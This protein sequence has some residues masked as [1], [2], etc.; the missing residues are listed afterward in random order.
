MS[1]TQNSR[2]RRPYLWVPT[3]YMAEGIPY[4][5]VMTLAGIMYNRMGI[6]NSEMALFTSL[7]GLPWVIKPL[8]SPIV[9][10]LGTKRR[11]I[12]A[13]QI[14]IACGFASVGLVMPGE[15]YFRL[16]MASFM[17]VAF[18]SATHDIAADGFY[19]LA[20]DTR[21]Q[22]FYVGIR[23]TFYRV[24]MMLGQGPLVMLAGSLEITCGEISHGWAMVFYIL[25]ACFA[26]TALYHSLILPR[27]VNDCTNSHHSLDDVWHEF[28]G[29]FT[30]FFTKPHILSALCFM[31][32]YRMPEAQLIRLIPPFLLDSPEAGGLGL[33]TTQEG[34]TYGTVGVIGLL[35]GG[36]TGGMVTAFGG[37]R[38]WLIPMAWSMSLT[39]L[40]FVYLGYTEEPSLL[41][42]NICV[43]I[44]QFGYGFGCT[45]Y[46]LY[47]ISFSE[48][49]RPASHYAICTGIMALGMM[50]PG[51]AA[52]YIQEFLGYTDF[53]LWCTACCAATI[54]VSHTVRLPERKHTS[55]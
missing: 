22:S 20:L 13:T 3:L 6:P 17:A 19:M 37:L 15:M 14:L 21:N 46:T 40:S 53:F 32:L 1:H 9:D 41:T 25:S 11:W 42:V 28:I 18:L 33:T 24:A 4:V 31:L 50:L 5:V 51:M 30:S 36:I 54:L 39:C 8:W 44:E 29:A 48:G 26:V 52:G 43:C 23:T 34:F 2:I 7:L 35:V 38:R 55:S 49:S 16:S 45:A 12:I 47:L 27:P 10:I